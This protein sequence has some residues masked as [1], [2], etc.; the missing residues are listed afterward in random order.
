MKI[1]ALLVAFIATNLTPNLCAIDGIPE[2]KYLLNSYYNPNRLVF[3]LSKYSFECSMLGASVP[4]FSAKN[5]CNSEKFAKISHLTIGYMQNNLNL[6]QMYSVRVVNGYCLVAY[7]NVVLNEKMVADGFAVVNKDGAE[8][9]NNG[10]YLQKLRQMQ[11]IAKA[12]K[13]GLWNSFYDEMQCF[14]ESYK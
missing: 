3:R 12:Q 1:F 13:L 14:S 11:S 5:P 2:R 7:S 9:F 4:Y 8:A 10:L 6:E